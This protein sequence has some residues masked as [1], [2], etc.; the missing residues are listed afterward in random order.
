[1]KKAA[2]I[3][4]RLILLL[5]ALFLLI[6]IAL[7]IPFVQNFVKDKAVTYLEDKIKTKVSNNRNYTLL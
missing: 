1:M 5:V 4:L 7:Q 3:L 2:K 6:V